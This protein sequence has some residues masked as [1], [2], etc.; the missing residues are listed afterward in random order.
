MNVLQFPLIKITVGFILGLI[1]AYYIPFSLPFSL[2]FVVI[3]VLNLLTAYWFAVK[4]NIRGLY[5]EGATLLLCFAI[6]IG[7]LITHTESNH[8]N[9][10]T[11]HPEVFQKANWIQVAVRERLRSSPQNNRYLALLQSI[12]AK[13]SSGKIILT[14][15]KNKNIQAFEVGHQLR[16]KAQLIPPEK[17][18]NPNQFDYAT[19]LRNK[20]IYA[21]VDLDP[22]A[23]SYHK[24][25][26]KDIWYYTS[27]LR[28]IIVTHLEKSG[29]DKKALPVA[30]A[31]LVGQQQDIDPNITKE[32]QYAG[33]VHI[34]SVSGLHIGFI[35]L[36][37]NFLLR[38][39]PNTSKGR[40]LKL[41]LSLVSLAL[42]GI[43][44]GLAPSV[45]RSITMFSFVAIG[46]YLR[47]SSNIYH[48]LVVSIFLILLFQPYFLFDVGFQLSYA[49]L[50]FIVWLQPLLASYWTPKNKI[51]EFFWDIITV[52]FAAQLGTLPLSIYYFHQF[53]GLFFVTN[54]LVLPLLSVIMLLG[55]IVMMI[56]TF[57]AMPIWCIKPLEWGITFM[58][59]IIGWV[60][61]FESFIFTNIPSTFYLTLASY[62]LLI[63]LVLWWK[64]NSFTRL[65]CTLSSII[66][67]QLVVLKNKLDYG[68]SKE[69]VVLNTSKKTIICQR[70]G[71]ELEVISNDLTNE[72]IQKNT[73]LQNYATATFSSIEKRSPLENFAYFN[74]NRILILDSS[75]VY[76]PN[77]ATDILLLTASPKV[78]L[79]RIIKDNRP[80]MVVADASNYKSLVTLWK[81]TC[82]KQ[83]IP[84]HS[85][86]EKG[87]FRI[88]E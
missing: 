41:S 26:L 87:Y 50:F 65:V 78:N 88:K 82:I 77:K 66:I 46:Q 2:A 17:P 44:A 68:N 43:L 24:T 72:E 15:A 19:Y 1:A 61:S 80:K 35:V 70:I 30:M 63:A 58:N 47:R 69:W 75:S 40:F 36:L 55:V 76:F 18:K 86:R 12:N 34:L 21:Q 29:F 51:L 71:K 23:I 73:V 83:N 42:F 84:F 81:T 74:G 5:F 48:T 22:E 57:T 62:G 11:N 39:I 33:A 67:L 6:G 28:T 37:I 54:L 9:N 13:K 49:A 10:Y 45:V 85:T 25:L 8:K 56:A 64:K 32:Y 16:F 52:S 20:Q 31:L 59:A 38:P 14:I 60:A 3:A 7:V 4:K 79:E 53:P 27:K